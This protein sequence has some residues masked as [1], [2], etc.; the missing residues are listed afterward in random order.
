MAEGQEQEA[1]PQFQPVR[2][3]ARIEVLD[4]M[5]G[6][7]ILAIFFF[8]IPFMAGPGWMA[9]IEPRAM[10]WAPADQTAWFLMHVT[11]EGTQ[12]GLLEL[13]FG[14]AAMVLTA[15]IMAPD[16]PV[17]A[18]DLY[19][20]RNLWLLVFGLIDIGVLLWGGDILHVYA[21]AALL[22]FP[23]RH[24]AVRWLMTI[25]LSIAMLSVIFGTSSYIE[26]MGEQQAWQQASAAEAR[27]E[28]LDK[29]QV[30]A[31]KTWDKHQ[32][33]IDKPSPEARAFAETEMKARDGSFGDYAEMLLTVYGKMYT[34]GVPVFTVM[35]AFCV[36][37]LGM[38]L[39]KLGFIQ[40]RA[41]TRSYAVVLALT[42]GY[43]MTARWIGLSDL[44]TFTPVPNLTWITGESSR[45]AISVG[46]VALANLLMR[47]A[48]GRWLLKPFLAAG[49][50]AFTLYF[51]EQIIGIHVLFSPV[52]MD[53]PGAQGWAHLYT[54]ALLVVVLLLIFANL[55]MRHFVSG[56]MEWAWR[57]LTYRSRQPFRRR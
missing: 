33:R 39:W 47:A 9:L 27:G 42:Y 28:K 11:L 36:M 40:G 19:V 30:E 23:L 18:A 6:F 45:I 2:G 35:E 16:G 53:L 12:R 34:K 13:L 44:M 56:P 25:G 8:N 52:V 4:A 57:S 38:A 54:Q 41:E 49:Q 31:I 26:R 14:A 7:A 37:L 48:M 15:R 55:W 51:M 20:R 21:I 3:R 10:G 22:V 5:R 43:G 46:H 24:L 32:M 29:P 17:A 50:M 1:G